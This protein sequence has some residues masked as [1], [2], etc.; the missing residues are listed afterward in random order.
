MSAVN[1]EITIAALA[2]LFR[3]V[4]ARHG[5]RKAIL[6]GS[7]ARGDASRRSDV[8]LILCFLAQQGAEKAMKALWYRMDEEPWGHSVQRLLQDFAHKATIASVDR[9]EEHAADLEDV[10][11]AFQKVASQARR[12]PD[13]TAVVS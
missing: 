1:S 10:V 4:L 6:F 9:C 5:I 7:R 12:L 3:P 8:D 13:G 11:K 2:E